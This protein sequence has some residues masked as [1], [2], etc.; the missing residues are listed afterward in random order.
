MTISNIPIAEL[1]NRVLPRHN[2][3]HFMEWMA[4]LGREHHPRFGAPK[5]ALLARY[6][7]MHTVFMFALSK[8]QYDLDSRPYCIEKAFRCW[9]AA[10]KPGFISAGLPSSI[11]GKHMLIRERVFLNFVRKNW[12]RI[13]MTR[14]EARA[15]EN[16][17]ELECWI[18]EIF[19]VDR[20]L[21]CEV[22][23]LD[24]PGSY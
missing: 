17:R 24:L 16:S 2:H 22:G 1:Q 10:C 20:V 7:E 9:Q 8:L 3:N 6:G 15:D 18:K 23:R 14:A 13:L 12:S 19:K 5:G 11:V 4:K 21:E